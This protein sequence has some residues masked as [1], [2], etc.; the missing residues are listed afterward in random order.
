MVGMS[1]LVRRRYLMMGIV[2][3]SWLIAGP[4][5]WSEEAKPRATAAESPVKADEV[6]GP[7][8]NW[9]RFHG[10]KA[11]NI[12]S[13]T[14]L[15]KQWPQQGPRLLWT[16][17]G[18][19]QG[20]AGVTIANGRI[21]TAGDVGDHLVIFALNMEGEVLWRGSSG[22][23]WRETG[24]PGAGNAHDRRRSALSRERPRRSCLPGRQD[25]QEDL[26]G[27]PGLAIPG[28]K[29]WVRAGRIGPD[30]R[31]PCDLLPRWGDGHGGARQEDRPDGLEVSECG[32]A[33]RLCLAHSGGVRG[34]TDGFHD[35]LQVP[36][37]RQRGQRRVALAIR[38]LYPA[39]RGQLR[40]PHL[41]RRA[42]FPERRIR[43]RLRAY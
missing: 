35:G 24:P 7:V 22:S 38:A 3:L 13:E 14:G 1:K 33:G 10:P 37:L 6:Q 30:R 36:D 28:Q 25:G 29:G 21:Y 5:V 19:G 12:S 27:Q 11:D 42:R 43:A 20:F 8:G 41:P 40:D 9:P 31:R 17:K 15:L 39:L 34:I 32:R 26:G 16:A 4:R 23:A 18:I 2:L